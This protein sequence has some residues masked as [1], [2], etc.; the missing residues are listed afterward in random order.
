MLRV[1]LLQLPVPNNP[2]A[3]VPLAAGYLKA[4]AEAQ[5]LLE[6]CSIEI[7]PRQLVDRAGDAMIVAAVVARRPDLLGISLYTWNSERSLHILTRIKSLLPELVV[8]VGGPEVQR[9]NTW[10][11]E[12]PAVDLAVIGEGEQTF[13]DVLRWQLLTRK[14]P[15]E[16]VGQ[17]TLASNSDEGAPLLPSHIP[18]LAFRINGEIVVT[19]TRRGLDDLSVV[20]SP[21]LRGYLELK[22]G[23]MAFVECS[24]WCPYR[25]TF[26]LYGRNMGSKLGKRLFPVER[27]VAEVAWAKVRGAKAVHFV[28]ANLNLLP[29]FRE[30]TERLQVLNSERELPLYAELRGEHLH[31]LAVAELASA[32]LRVAEVGLQSANPRALQAVERRTDL[33]KWAAGTRRL[34][35]HGIEVLLDVILGL[36][37]DDAAGVRDTLE[38]IEEQQ[39]GPYEVFVLQV[40][41]GTTVRERSDS[42]GLQYQDRPPYYV[43]H[44]DRLS[45][46]E[47][48]ALRWELRERTGFDPMAVEGMPELNLGG[49]H[50]PANAASPKFHD[51]PLDQYTLDCAEQADWSA[52]GRRLAPRVGAH[53]TLFVHDFDPEVLQS[54]AWPIAMDNLTIHWDVVLV[55]APPP[56]A[57]LRALHAAWPHEVGYLHRIAVYQRATPEQPYH[58]V[59]PRWTLLV[60]WDTTVDPLAYEGIAQVVWQVRA[61]D[62][63]SSL[64]KIAAYGGSGLLIVGKDE[65][66]GEVI[67][68]W[69]EATGLSVWWTETG[70]MV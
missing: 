59:S 10:I 23:D 63:P 27:V 15:Q 53:F 65:V 22:P 52:R 16:D 18:G 24:R 58:K 31:E 9:D 50:E 25:C 7:L 61:R 3:N 13:C 51:G 29:Y 54:F 37:S 66:P 5:G 28:E 47:L 4:Y 62:L 60:P 56:P 48:R 30:L 1:V 8:V 6:G 42:Y 57:I 49:V 34:Y 26:C 69:Q 14:E 45:F 39:L 32:G 21:Y 11:L 35:E 19:E 46:A 64:D 67:S 70:C 12:H 41:P 36:P 68:T 43:L 38:W 44:T 40:L 20:P 33:L 17:F 55:G 2:Q